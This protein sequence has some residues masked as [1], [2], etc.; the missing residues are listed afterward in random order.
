MM[1]T[2]EYPY[3]IAIA[4]LPRWRTERV[5]RLIVEIIHNR[6]ISL[7]DFFAL[8]AKDWQIDFEITDAETIA[9]S[10]VKSE[11]PNHAFLVEDLLKQGF[12][13]IPIN[14]KAYSPVLKKNLGIKFAPPLLYVK[15]NTKLLHEP[16]V[17]IVGSRNASQ[18]AMEFADR[19]A[20][21]CT[22]QYRSVVSKYNGHSVIVLPQ[23]IMTF[24]SGIRKYYNQ[25]VEGNV[26]VLSTFHPKAGW[27]VGLAMAR[28]VYIYGLAEE[29]YV[30]ESDSKGGTW[31]GVSD[32]LKKDRII[33]VR[34]P[35]PGE[36]NANHLLIEKG[37]V[38]VDMEGIP[39]PVPEEMKAPL[40]GIAEPASNLSPPDKVVSLEE[41]VIEYLTEVN[42]PRTS[43]Q[44][45]EG[46]KIQI[47][48]RE[49]AT[50]LSKMVTLKKIKD[51]QVKWEINHNMDGQKQG[52][53]GLEF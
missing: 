16:S 7:K 14:E 41:R 4:H 36:K 33:Y 28:N 49:L 30:A 43:K 15:G 37:A 50:K 19:V 13:I 20:Q 48:T 32:G 2:T 29:I 35:E 21:K 17:A 5:N 3:W 31:S 6:K 23:G 18:K 27:D 44:I 39:Q 25:I 51:K 10:E 38:A 46:L 26:L 52:N 40:V 12:Q 42:E 53:L 1:D 9:L 8:S 45:K 34:Q 24:G 22:Y 47:D 11:L